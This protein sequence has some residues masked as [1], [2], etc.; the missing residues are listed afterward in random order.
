MAQRRKPVGKQN[1]QRW[2]FCYYVVYG[3]SQA[4]A[5]RKAAPD[6]CK[7]KSVDHV[8]VTASQWARSDSCQKML[9]QIRQDILAE[10]RLLPEQHM[11]KLREIRDAA[12]AKGAYTA[13][14]RAEELRGK[15]MGF[16]V[17]RS[18]SVEVQLSEPEILDRLQRISAANPDIAQLITSATDQHPI[19][20]SPARSEPVQ[21]AA[22]RGENEADP[23]GQS[24]SST[25]AQDRGL[26]HEKTPAGA[27]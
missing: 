14:I 24:A 8:A 2:L 10:E 9:E 19:I 12:I 26:A 21:V 15:C 1:K 13:A 3:D 22:N 5:L 20:E 16:Y 23:K 25:Q 4:E 11:A 27:A 17:D 6:V 7:N 18:L